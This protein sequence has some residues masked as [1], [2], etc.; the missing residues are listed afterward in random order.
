VNSDQRTEMNCTPAEL[1]RDRCAIALRKAMAASGEFETIKEL[2]EGSGVN[3]S[4]LR[5][6]FQGR[7]LPSE[8]A[9]RAL[10]ETLGMPSQI[11]PG[12]A[13]R[14]SS[15]GH[16]AG[17]RSRTRGDSTAPQKPAHEASRKLREASST[18][19]DTTAASSTVRQ[20][21]PCADAGG[22]AKAT[23][24]A[25]EAL[26]QAREVRRQI[27][28]LAVQLEYFKHGTPQDRTALRRIIP[29]RDMGYLTSLLRALYDEDQFEAWIL[30]SEYSLDGDE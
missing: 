2:A 10:Q 6:Y 28:Q 4:T 15:S 27:R 3:Y 21:P 17:R 30:F 26:D 16:G 5:G 20:R 25:R 8:A 23:T 7:A 29:G 14:A 12:T 9:W 18:D 1:G 22:E 24:P 13:A 19:S 11:A